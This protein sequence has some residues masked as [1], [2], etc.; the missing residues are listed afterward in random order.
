MIKFSD[1]I[2]RLQIIN[3]MATDRKIIKYKVQDNLP[4]FVKHLAMVF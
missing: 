4:E 2:D 1:L 3:F